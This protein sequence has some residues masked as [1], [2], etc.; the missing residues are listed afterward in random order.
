M[1][2][3]L[4]EKILIILSGTEPNV[5]YSN[6]VLDHRTRLK[7]F[8][9]VLELAEDLQPEDLNTVIYIMKGSAK[10]SVILLNTRQASHVLEMAGL[11]IL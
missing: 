6:L 1:L 3:Y 4:K 2:Y 8:I 7:V 10:G 5:L 11:N 9:I